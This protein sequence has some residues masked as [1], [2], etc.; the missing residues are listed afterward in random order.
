[1]TIGI[2]F[3]EAIFCILF[4]YLFDLFVGFIYFPGTERYGVIA[5]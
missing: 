3:S 4:I 2:L 1:M 5:N